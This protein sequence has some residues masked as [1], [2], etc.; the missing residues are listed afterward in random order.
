MRAPILRFQ[1]LVLWVVLGCLWLM[2]VRAASPAIM[3]G[4]SATLLPD[5]RWLLLGGDGDAAGKALVLNP[6]T[7]QPVALPFGL[8]TPRSR[9]S[10]TVLPD[11]RVLV[12]G[13]VGKGGNV[14]GDAEL[15]DPQ[16]QSSTS[17][18]DIGVIPRASH[19]A[20]VLM[21]GSVL[22]AGGV[23]GKGVP[24]AQ[25]DLWDPVGKQALGVHAQ[26]V[27]PR[28]GHTAQLL[29][30][31]PVLIS[32]GR[33]GAGNVVTTSER[34]FPQQQRFDSTPSNLASLSGGSS[35]ALQ[36]Q[37]SLP[38]ANAVG[39]PI[40]A[41]LA[42]RFSKPLS[43]TSLNPKTVTLL[44]PTG[45]VSVNVVPVEQG[46]LLFV[47]PQA[48]LQPGAR[49]TLFIN[50]A[51]DE[52]GN[53]L[54]FTAVG[55]TA[56]SLS[57]GG[58]TKAPSAG[59]SSTSGQFSQQAA[60]QATT[61]AAVASQA[62]SVV[63]SAQVQAGAAT[64][65]LAAL[66]TQHWIPGA[67]HLRGDWRIKLPASPLQKLPPLAAAAGVTAL[68]GQ[69]LLMNGEAAV[70]V[71]LTLYG[72]TT[73][74]DATGRF[75]IQASSAGAKTLIIDGTSANRPGK[76]YGYFEVFVLLEAGK[77]TA[78][79]YT[80]WMPLIDTA[81]T[82]K[83]DSPTRSE[84]V[85]TTPFIPQLEVRIPKGT[86]LRDRNGR[87]INELSIT[88]IPIDRSPYPLPTR[89]VPVYFT[90]QPGGA[91]IQGV[92]A[93]SAQGARVIYPNY[94]HGE[95]GSVL[96]FWNY[97]PVQR[98][99]YVYGQGK[100]AAN[101]QQIVPDPG[102]SIYELTG[103]MVSKPSNAPA[104]G[105]APGGCPGAS[106]GPKRATPAPAA[107]DNPSPD[108]DPNC[109]NNSPAPESTP[110]GDT[111][112]TGGKG[113]PS[114]GG[115]GGDPV[116][117][118]TGLFL[119]TR[120]DLTVR[121]TV[122]L[123]ITRTYRQGDSI[124]RAFGIGTN[125]SY[126]TFTVG[127]YG[128]WTYQDLILPDGGRIHFVRTSPGTG[129]TDA[130]YTHTAT[131]TAYYGAVI[132]WASGRWQLKMRDGRIMYF[133]ECMGCV[134]SQRAAMTEFDDR[135]GNKITLTRDA[136]GNLTQITNPD[137]RYISL[138]YDSSNRVTQATDNIGRSVGYQYDAAGRLAQVTDADGGV[139][140][141]SYDASSNMLTVTKPNGQPMVT[142]Q[143]DAN[144]RVVRQT[145]AD[146]GI[147]QFA[148]T[149]DPNGNVVQTDV[150]D[151]RGN[152]R[153][154][155][156][157]S[158][159][160][161]TSATNALGLP[162]AQTTTF[163][164][165]AGT[166][167]L[168]S[169]T[170]TLGRKTT[171]A[172][173]NVGNLTG[174]TY[175][176]GTPQQV[177]RA[178]T[179][180]PLFNQVTSHT[181]ELGHITNFG[182][183]SAGNRTSVTDPLGNAT[184]YSYN[185]VGQ[186]TTITNALGKALALTYSQG[187]LVAVTDPLG[188]T[189]NRYTDGVGRLLSVT[190]PLGNV[191][192]YDYNGR[193]LPIKHTDAKGNVTTF[194]YDVDGNMTSLTDARN[195]QT[196][197]SYDAK[198]RLI[199][200]TDPLQQSE[201]YSYDAVDN[202]AQLTDRNGKIAAFTYDGLSR[203]TSAAYGQTS[204]GGTPGAPDATATYTFDAGSRM[205]QIVDSVGGTISRS[206]DSLD[207]LSS[208]TTP[209]GSISYGYDNAG[210]RTAMTVAGQAPVTYSYDNDSRLT[211]VTQGSA[212]VGFTYDAGSRRT[213]LTLPNGIVA[214][215]SYDI[216]NQLVGISYA[217]GGTQLGDLTYAYDAGGKRIQMAGS[218]ANMMLPAAISSATY[219]AGN[220]LT[221]W[222][223]VTL[224][225]DNNGNLLSDGSLMYTWDSRNRLSTLSGSAT[226]SFTY[227]AVGR[228]SSKSIGAIT[229]GFF[230][231]GSNTVQELSGGAVSANLLKGTIDE[232]FSRTDTTFGTRYFVTDAQRSTLALTDS[233]GV[234]QA[235]YAYEPYGATASSGEPNSNIAQY[236]GRENDGT[237]LYYYR[238]RYYHPKFMRF[239]S[240][241]PIGF[242]GGI[243]A[244]AYVSGNPIS[245]ADPYGFSG[246]G[247]HY[248]RIWVPLC[249]F[250]TRADGF[251]AMRNFSAPGAPYAV[252]GTHDLNLTGNNPIRQTVDSCNY[253]ITNKTL[254]GH[255]FGGQVE[256]SITEMNGAVGAEVVGS[257]YGPNA[258]W[259]QL[260]G[261]PI[262]EGLG[263]GAY[264]R[265]NPRVGF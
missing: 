82:V 141:Y 166:N 81:H 124:S 196:T 162:E 169:Q 147:Y 163:E 103:A 89:Y 125:H 113:A 63:E 46:R 246:E 84:V 262:F 9:H 71:T 69:V 114:P 111:P 238:A 221:N 98:G 233:S 66:S 209:Q 194:T 107:P 7:Q 237:G 95:P 225:Y 42:V 93:A 14:V 254:P 178:Y 49:Y 33:D 15:L 55:F 79:P 1:W 76:T 112:P 234:V 224:A 213:T 122:P 38:A 257:G 219:D 17:L 50:A 92:D 139:E 99:W 244:Y 20:T 16:A 127:D 27:V 97:D 241:D 243:N 35:D 170:D 218:L 177:T 4:Q 158:S 198:D 47:T 106:G 252:D 236:T 73:Q 142:N 116:D 149:L 32:G 37:D 247:D 24:V 39:V 232:L 53:P 11:G 161:V 175:L 70:G 140:K 202:L 131:P 29:P 214:T 117:C 248:Y 187:D 57:G 259:N 212:Q 256:I 215:Y 77:T 86:V 110:S 157:N 191:T 222:V 34:Y 18:G 184:R 133:A 78:L 136:N 171:Y 94:H 43:V 258:F 90:L 216:A 153:R 146:G 230:Y 190:D 83:F 239:T 88:P 45:S 102:V 64:Q 23:S 199:S 189:V 197:F 159:G 5:G 48:D 8:R 152:V 151:P 172:Y 31:E 59:A 129:Y 228:R 168:L 156:F 200:K 260:F 223:G 72:Q 96:D 186:V 210:R 264:L 54:P 180:E 182:Y 185:G 128:P 145:L 28:A 181:D 206:Y 167:L 68:A 105:P 22:I 30:D 74:T 135:L 2:P 226:A 118:Y 130:V 101:G 229:T 144:N 204:A 150:T 6:G 160:Y 227:D 51:V 188:R 41:R 183:D 250:C 44:G 126:D 208:E 240:Q 176:A 164:R 174:I 235:S 67:A 108:P 109:R 121:G 155:A 220:R 134:S 61:S 137:G 211:G 19:T 179:Y 165:Q 143:Y 25:A 21:D 56:G 12:F 65:S 217:N 26:M 205:T 62:T 80:S 85:V 203:R 120:T 245:L 119:H 123:S 3:P 263:F 91:R 138:T 261:P 40:T 115:C 75:V 132:K 52:V 242:A 207:R 251:E 253:K 58:G 265:L 249:T 201:L 231:D 154:M 104:K 193:S 148:Y 192:S 10:A 60:V 195:S 255:M 173:D 87:V 36:V 13:G 100:I